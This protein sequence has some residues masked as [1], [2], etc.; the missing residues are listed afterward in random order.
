[1]LSAYKAVERFTVSSIV[2][3]RSEAQK[4]ELQTSQINHLK[5]TW[6]A[7]Q[8][9][10]YV[11][12]A[13]LQEELCKSSAAFSSEQ[14]LDLRECVGKLVS[15]KSPKGATLQICLAFETMM[16]QAQ[17]DHIEAL[18][19]FRARIDAVVSFMLFY[20]LVNPSE[21]TKLRILTMLMLLRS[22]DQ[23]SPLAFYAELT[24]MGKRVAKMRGPPGRYFFQRTLDVFPEC[25]SDFAQLYPQ[26]Y[27]NGMPVASKVDTNT[28]SMKAQSYNSRGNGAQ[29]RSN[30]AQTPLP[31]LTMSSPLDVASPMRGNSLESLMMT[32]SPVLMLA[33]QLG[34]GSMPSGLRNVDQRASSHA[35]ENVSWQTHQRAQHQMPPQ[36]PLQDA[37]PQQ[38]DTRVSPLAPG[39]A[40]QIQNGGATDGKAQTLEQVRAE[41]DAALAAKKAE[42][43]L[44]G[45]KKKKG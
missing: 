15:G 27:L 45:R 24:H 29:V 4:L 6:S 23:M 31:Q 18:E 19:E 1:M 16:T 3:L 22:R 25:G 42:A 11:D 21:P 40:G 7:M 8:S 34:G 26:L 41:V 17:W 35:L 20:G 10:D 9:F 37:T 32:L 5:S 14:L 36:L 43:L 44:K 2:G 12:A 28:I 39:P 30:G 13:S 33:Q 38:G